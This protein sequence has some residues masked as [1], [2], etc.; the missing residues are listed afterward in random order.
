[1]SYDMEA[2]AKLPIFGALT[3]DTIRF[4]RERCEEVRL[5]AGE[6]F[7][8]QGET[9]DSLFV[10]REGRV[11]VLRTVEGRDLVL[12]ELGAGTC[13]GEMALVAISPRCATVRALE[14]CRALKLTNLALL[15]LY[16]H[17]LEQFTLLQMNLG[18]EMA[19]RLA[20]ADEALFER[21]R[22]LGRATLDDPL[23]AR[24]AATLK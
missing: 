20:A 5:G 17:D 2:L 23:L 9:G 21:A 13:F 3:P 18:R 10:L 1:M 24:A 12:A 8:T 15:D 14:D 11:G 16:H 4:L 22:S 7:F 6:D 19:R